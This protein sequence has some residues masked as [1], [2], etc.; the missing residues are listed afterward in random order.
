MSDCLAGVA[1]DVLKDCTSLPV[2]GLEK[3]AYLFNRDELTPTYDATNKRLVT[4]LAVSTGNQGYKI[5]GFNLDMNAGH[6]LVTSETMPDKYAQTFN[7]AAWLL[8]AEA[9]NNLDQLEDVVVVVESKNQHNDGDGAFKIYGLETGLYKSAD[10]HLA[11]DND[12]TRLVTLANR[13]GEAS[14]ASAHVFFDTDYATTK[15]A[16]EALLVTQV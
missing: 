11:N 10:D 1:A 4:A 9:V 7:F 12:G 3:V 16:L 13:D 8:D 6:S 5:E 2:R 14:S 15:A